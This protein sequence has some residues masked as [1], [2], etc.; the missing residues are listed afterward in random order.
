M[1]KI[2]FTALMISVGFG[3]YAHKGHEHHDISQDINCPNKMVL[4]DA[5]K[6]QLKSDT[7]EFSFM[8]GPVTW[9]VFS[10][11]AIDSGPMQIDFDNL[12]M[13]DNLEL[14]YVSAQNDPYWCKAYFHKKNESNIVDNFIL[15][16]DVAKIEMK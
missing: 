4:R 11:D 14:T 2:L 13:L 10:I 3:A 1:K 6:I 8:D 12:S 16:F 9:N 7:P 5:L 15:K